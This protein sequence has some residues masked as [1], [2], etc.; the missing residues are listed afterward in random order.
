[1]AF[2]EIFK[3][4]KGTSWTEPAGSL[5]AMIIPQLAKYG[6]P[7]QRDA[8]LNM[9]K[10]TGSLS[11]AKGVVNSFREMQRLG[12]SLE[13]ASLHYKGNHELDLIFSS[14]RTFELP[15]GW[16]QTKAIKR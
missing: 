14:G 4:N 16:P 9:V 10:Q 15:I 3:V 8:L 2:D 11:E 12:Y 1:M 5:G 13:N 6:G 7:D